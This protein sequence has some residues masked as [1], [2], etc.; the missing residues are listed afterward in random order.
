MKNYLTIRNEDF[1][2]ILVEEPESP[3][4]FTY[5]DYLTWNFKERIELIRGKIFRMC[6]APT[7]V[8][9][10]IAVNIEIEL[11]NYLR[12]KSCKFFHAPIDVRLKGIEISFP[13]RTRRRIGIVPDFTSTQGKG[14]KGYFSQHRLPEA[15]LVEELVFRLKL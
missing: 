14:R 8:H 5:A 15:G 13:G 11:M 6:P 3:V 2:E 12:N 4:G 9:Q 7:I 1:S 10:Q